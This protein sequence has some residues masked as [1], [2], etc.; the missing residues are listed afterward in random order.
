MS[1]QLPKNESCQI[2]SDRIVGVNR[3]YIWDVN[4]VSPAVILGD[5]LFTK[6]TR[7]H[8]VNTLKPRD[9]TQLAD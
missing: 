6:V 1:I 4:R 8:F 3:C 9:T 5:I 7:S 2:C